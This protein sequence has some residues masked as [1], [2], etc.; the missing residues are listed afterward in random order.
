MLSTAQSWWRRVY[1]GSRADEILFRLAW[2]L[3]L[4][5]LLFLPLNLADGNPRNI[6]GSVLSLLIP[7]IPRWMERR[8]PHRFPALGEF[9]VLTE[10][11][12][13]SVVRRVHP[14]APRFLFAVLL[15]AL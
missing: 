8:S 11:R 10:P 7:L 6:V 5:L 14:A 13:L 3:Y 2:L 15:F 12:H 1:K 9:V 4:P